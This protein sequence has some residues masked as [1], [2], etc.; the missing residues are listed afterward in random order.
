MAADGRGTAAPTVAAFCV[1]DFR[2]SQKHE[3]F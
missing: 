2:P 3:A 1:V